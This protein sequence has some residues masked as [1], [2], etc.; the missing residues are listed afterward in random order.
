VNPASIRKPRLLKFKSRRD[1]GTF[2][3]VYG[4]PEFE[5]ISAVT[6]N[7]DCFTDP[8]ELRRFG[9]WCLQAAAWM[10]RKRKRKST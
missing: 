3:S 1:P 7:P 8:K 9:F 5:D 2:A 4:P 6:Q 10:E